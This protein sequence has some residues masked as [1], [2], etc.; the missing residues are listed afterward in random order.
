MFTRQIF[1]TPGIPLPIKGSRKMKR[2]AATRVVVAGMAIFVAASTMLSGCSNNSTDR[3]VDLDAYEWAVFLSEYRNTGYLPKS[4]SGYVA[5][6]RDDGSYDLIE[7]AGMDQGQISWTEHGIN[8]ADA[9]GDHWITAKGSKV[10]EQ[11]RVELMDGLVTLSDGLT[12]VG[13]YNAG[14]QKKGYREEVVIS[15]PDSSEHRALT[16]VGFYPMIS[17]CG[18]DV[19]AAYSMTPEDGDARFIFDQIVNDGTVEHTHVGTE[20]VPF[21]EFGYI[22]RDAPCAAGRIYFLGG[23]VNYDGEQRA[24]NKLLAPHMQRTSGGHKHAFVLVTVDTGTGEVDWLPLTTDNG[25]NLEISPEEA[26]YSAVDAHSL[27]GDGNLVWVGGNGVLYRTSVKTGQTTVLSD[28]LEE[29]QHGTEPEWLYHFSSDD[30]T[31]TVL[32][33]D[34]RDPLAKPRIVVFNKTSGKIIKDIQINGLKRDVSDAMIL[35]DIAQK[36]T[37]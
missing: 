16:T 21:S 7:H 31:V 33:E 32:V 2:L 25:A 15:R 26:D 3:E 14:R 4:L 10:V 18:D 22:T 1:S 12:R 23:F 30:D 35:R 37:E 24:E 28:E 9:E 17:A 19:Y 20:K 6:V 36:P 34:T 5:L 29:D 13:V 8:F 27:D 11:D